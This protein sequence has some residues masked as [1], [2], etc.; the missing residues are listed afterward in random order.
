M[1]VGR[2]ARRVE[3]AERVVRQARIAPGPEHAAAMYG[4]LNSVA[5]E[6]SA[7]L[8]VT[9]VAEFLCFAEDA[10][11]RDAAKPLGNVR[12]TDF[13]RERLAR[14]RRESDATKV[15]SVGR[16]FVAVAGYIEPRLASH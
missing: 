16:H 5:T 6:D 15:K 13:Y 4:V 14:L 12:A 3:D 11:A 1:N 9:F 10:G 2:R 8:P 7:F